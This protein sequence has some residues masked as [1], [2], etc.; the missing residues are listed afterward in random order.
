MRNTKVHYKAW[1]AALLLIIPL[2]VAAIDDDLR[3]I[4]LTQNSDIDNVRH[5]LNN[6]VDVNAVTGDGTTALHWAALR[7]DIKIAELL[8]QSGANVNPANDYG[9][10]PLWLAC[11]NRSTPMVDMLLQAGAD[12]NSSLLTGETVLMNCAR[13]GATEAVAALLLAEADVNAAE[14]NNGQTALM[15]AVAEGHSDVTRLLINNG[16]EIASTT[17]ESVATVQHTCR[18]CP[19][20]SSPGGFTPLL[21]AARAGDLESA[22]LLVEAGADPNEANSEHGNS[23][24]IASAGG[25]GDLALYLLKMGAD[26]N[27]KDD[28]GITA[29]HHA[30]GGGLSALNGVIYD[31]VYRIRPTNNIIL[32]KALLEAGADPNAQIVINHLLGPDG[33]PFS[34]EGATPFFLAAV[35]AD[36][37]M[38]QLLKDFGAG[39]Q[40][41]TFEGTT[42]LMAAAHV[43]CTGTCAYQEGGNIAN[44]DDVELSL[45]AVKLVVEIGADVNAVNKAGQTSMHYAAFTGASP[46]VQF[47]ADRGAQVDVKDRNGETPWS[48]ASGIAPGPLG[49]YGNHK[50]TAA[51]LVKL[52]ANPVVNFD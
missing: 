28:T 42:P 40:L 6:S 2:L 32:A 39:P 25:H 37:P 44:K 16:V 22:R 48:M 15:W 41:N 19:W 29:L 45:Q 43:A 24:V 9:V 38:M 46:V 50:S 27:V 14:S 34:M 8:I 31:P 33:Y 21:F 35:S 18:V 17:T 26:P 11:T 13:T 10:T 4:E 52:G 12:P 3:L 36:I 7:D 30:V 51:L 20:T 1:S 5:L 49:S 47:L 23:L